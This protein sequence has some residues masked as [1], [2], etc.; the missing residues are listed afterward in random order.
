MTRVL[1][2]D[3]SATDRALVRGLLSGK[4]QWTV[5]TAA[6]G[7]EA[8]AQIETA[9]PDVVVTDLQMPRMNGLE[10]VTTIRARHPG[11][12]VIL[13]T[14]FGSEALAVEAL[15]KGAASY[16]P[17]SQ[18]SAKLVNTVEKVVALAR[19]D[20]NYEQLVHC[21][22][23]SEFT[24]SLKNDA[25]LIDPLVELVQQMVG[26]MEFCDFT[27]RFQIGAALKEALMNALFHGSL[28]LRVEQMQDA[29][30][31]LRR[32]EEVSLIKDPRSEPPYR[33]RRIFV[34]ATLSPDE[35]RFVIRDQGPG[36]D[37]AAVPKAKDPA[38][39]E[40]GQGRGLT[41]MQ[42]FMDEVIFSEAGNEVTMIKRRSQDT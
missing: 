41:I 13:M 23:R 35:V 12:P 38:A 9:R 31:K 37:V 25:A 34:H 27:E 14:A 4:S 2:V 5:Q 8:L 19:A 21:I 26:G 17:K 7:G 32:G 16:V 10:L 30:N 29:L 3:D 33:D 24:L 42:S 40:A 36:F 11:V 15:D 20:R 22:Q 18:L 39:L 6:D 28:E 1:V